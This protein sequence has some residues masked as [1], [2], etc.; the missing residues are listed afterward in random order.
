MDLLVSIGNEA[1]IERRQSTRRR[2]IYGGVVGY[3]RRQTTVE[4]VI[5]DFSDTGAHIEFTDPAVLP[6]IV[7]LLVAK[8]N[9][10]F[11]ARVAWRQSNRVGLA[12][13]AVDKEAPMPLDWVRRLRAARSDDRK[14]SSRLSALVDGQ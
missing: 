1:M 5:R 7:D 10:A 12:F 9:R 8:K 13:R 2:V 14:L 3:N 4:C 6:D 11:T